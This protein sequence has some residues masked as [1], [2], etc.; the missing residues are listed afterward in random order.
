V[1]FG[2][3]SSL[4]LQTEPAAS[5]PAVLRQRII[6]LDCRLLVLE[7]TEQ[8]AWPDDLRELVEHLACDVLI[9]R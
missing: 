9:I 1:G 6:E 3:P 2:A 4:S 8:D 7:A 5:E